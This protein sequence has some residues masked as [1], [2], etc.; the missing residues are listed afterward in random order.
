MWSIDYVQ[1]PLVTTNQ[2]PAVRAT[3]ND[4]TGLKSDAVNLKKA[5]LD[6]NKSDSEDCSISD[7]EENSVKEET[8]GEAAKAEKYPLSEHHLGPGEQAK[9]RPSL[10]SAK[11]LHERISNLGQSVSELKSTANISSLSQD[12]AGTST[13][14]PPPAQ[15]PPKLRPSK[16][17]TS[18]TDS[19]VVIEN[20]AASSTGQHCLRNGKCRNN[21]CVL[22]SQLF[23]YYILNLVR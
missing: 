22:P 21:Y 9:K 8:T 18:I 6:T 17:D 3:S 7:E 14:S 16:S 11:S 12:D 5:A 4:A 10:V 15:Q 1:V 13:S 2:S 19:F 20:V 23:D